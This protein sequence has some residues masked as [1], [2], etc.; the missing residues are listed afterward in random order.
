M[1][2]SD[3]KQSLE[4]LYQSIL[5]Q[6]SDG[7]NL[8]EANKPVE[9]IKCYY[10]T[11][12]SISDI[13]KNIGPSEG[14]S[15]KYLD[16]FDDLRKQVLMR[17]ADIESGQE[18]ER[19]PIV[20]ETDS[21][22]I[23]S[24]VFAQQDVEIFR[25]STENIVG[26]DEEKYDLQ[27][28]CSEVEPKSSYIKVADWTYPLIP[29]V[30]SIWC[31]QNGSYIFPAVYNSV[32]EGYVGISFPDETMESRL[33]FESLVKDLTKEEVY[34]EPVTTSQS[35]ASALEQGGQTL[36]TAAVRGAEFAGEWIVRGGSW[37]R[38]MIPRTEEP[39]SINRHLSTGMGIAVGASNVVF[40]VSGYVGMEVKLLR[41]LA[42]H[43]SPFSI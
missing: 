27:I 35:I 38:S 20:E 43:L 4:D 17:I 3:Q 21:N 2:T 15:R 39:T 33:A 7:L 30:C 31:N 24:V 12:T 41:W 22:Q 11:L 29:G 19:Q 42:I 6:I 32:S 26:R 18:A 8:D 14:D 10:E 37:I 23:F 13:V 36:G 9:A 28:L 5:A 25:I 34:V 40:K 16:I 1:E